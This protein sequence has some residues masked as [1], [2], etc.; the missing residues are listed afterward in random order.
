M[1]LENIANFHFMPTLMHHAEKALTVWSCLLVGGSWE[2]VDLL[3]GQHYADSCPHTVPEACPRTAP[4]AILSGYDLTQRQTPDQV[5][6]I[7]NIWCLWEQGSYFNF[8]NAL[9]NKSVSLLKHLETPW[10]CI[11]S[12]NT[13]PRFCGATMT[14]YTRRKL[15]TSAY[16]FW[17]SLTV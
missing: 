3:H 13:F 1:N 2:C 7:S 14:S 17:R 10:M 15:K 6:Y 5:S 4:E 12:T 16:Y 9:N 8:S 11:I